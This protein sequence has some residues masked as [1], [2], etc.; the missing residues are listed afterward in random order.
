[1]RDLAELYKNNI[2]SLEQLFDLLKRYQ[3]NSL[4]AY[5]FFARCLYPNQIFDILED[6]YELKKDVKK[7]VEYYSNTLTQFEFKLRK[8]HKFLVNNYQIR[9][10]SWL[11]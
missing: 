1:M 3:I 2:L 10:I 7:R 9:P 6:Y 11:E 8:L 4:D 5:L